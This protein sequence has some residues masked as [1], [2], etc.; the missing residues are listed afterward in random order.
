MNPT[1]YNVTLTNANTE[2]SQALPANSVR[3]A[4]QC[5]TATDVRF[6]FVSGKVAGAVA[7]FLTLKAGCSYDSGEMFV[8]GLT[9]YLASGTGG[10]IMEIEIWG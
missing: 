6:A 5:R 3:L 9:L 2:Y 7:P 4:F 8:G 1:I 10:V